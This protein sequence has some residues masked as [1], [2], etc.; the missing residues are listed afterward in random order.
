MVNLMNLVI[1]LQ[2]GSA[3]GLLQ[4]YIRSWSSAIETSSSS[5]PVCVEAPNSALSRNFLLPLSCEVTIY[6][7]LPH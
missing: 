7:S 3:K 4:C 2:Y 1:T 6:L 5:F